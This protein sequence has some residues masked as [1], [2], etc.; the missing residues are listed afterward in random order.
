M[1][2]SLDEARAVSNPHDAD[3]ALAAGRALAAVLLTDPRVHAAVEQW[4]QDHCTP[5]GRR[6]DSSPL[7]AAVALSRAL[8]ACVSGLGLDRY[9]WLSQFLFYA[10]LD[11]IGPLRVEMSVPALDGW[12]EPGRAPKAG[13]VH[14]EDLAR[15]V[16]WFY[17]HEIAVPPVSIRQLAA[18]YATQAGRT[19]DCRRAVQH[20][21]TRAR[22][23]VAGIG[24]PLLK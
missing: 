12:H 23:L 19:N 18:E 4:G 2:D 24:P 22:S 17:R 13:P 1:A 15:S 21:I 14:I 6:A 5:E 10:V 9:P 16:A 7:E 8:T 11:T 3:R 20:G